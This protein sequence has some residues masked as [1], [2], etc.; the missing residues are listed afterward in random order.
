MDATLNDSCTIEIDPRRKLYNELLSELE[1]INDRNLMEGRS[2]G[3][4]IEAALDAVLAAGFTFDPAT[5]LGR[6]LLS[7]LLER[8]DCLPSV[9]DYAL[10]HGWNPEAMLP[11]CPSA[12]A[13]DYLAWEAPHSL[14]V[15][16][17]TQ[18][19]QDRILDLKPN[20]HAVIYITNQGKPVTPLSQA[21]ATRPSD[22]EAFETLLSNEVWRRK[23]LACDEG[24]DYR[25]IHHPAADRGMT[26]TSF[27]LFGAN[28]AASPTDGFECDGLA[29]DMTSGSISIGR[30]GLPIH[31]DVF[32]EAED[33][34]PVAH[35]ASA[36]DSGQPTARF[37]AL[38][39]VRFRGEDLPKDQWARVAT[40]IFE[41]ASLI[42]TRRQDHRLSG[43]WSLDQTLDNRDFRFEPTTVVPIT[44]DNS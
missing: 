21:G 43:R 7:D 16:E 31:G 17:D 10:A 11:N 35:L 32:R 2:R 14:R 20:V 44:G 34:A 4:G 5:D 8:T 15:P 36:K 1:R 39:D 9:I 42:V 27:R 40:F 28:P 19:V 12:C 23:L 33:E 18:T 3:E 38:I 13:I 29:L 22:S 30:D 37:G 24:R 6:Y 26:C 25:A 41:H